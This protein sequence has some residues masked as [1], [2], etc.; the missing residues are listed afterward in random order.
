MIGESHAAV[1][2]GLTSAGSAVWIRRRILDRHLSGTAPSSLS[3]RIQ[4][5]SP[6]A[7]AGLTFTGVATTVAF[8]FDKFETWVLGDIGS[9]HDL[10]TVPFVGTVMTAAEIL[11]ESS[12]RVAEWLCDR[13]DI[14]EQAS[15]I[16][17]S[18]YD[19]GS[20]ILNG[21][22]AGLAAH[23]IQDLP[24]SGAGN[25]AIT[26]LK[27]LSNR[28]FN[29]GWWTNED[30]IPTDV[31][32]YGGG[33]LTAISWSAIAGYLITPAPPKQIAK[34]TL[35]DAQTAIET[36]EVCE[37]LQHQLQTIQHRIAETIESA[38]D[39]TEAFSTARCQPNS[40]Q[41]I[42]VFRADIDLVALTSAASTQRS[43]RVHTAQDPVTID[44]DPSGN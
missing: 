40:G 41:S 33:L 10:H 1:T 42:P 31:A 17:Q 43:E 19:L 14:P 24:G 2:A 6:E 7:L 22:V 12:Q 21:T 38:M 26:L 9:H 27:P 37:R 34:S 4:N 35:N 36:G 30:F 15:A 28:Q 44:P 13:L 16:G 5:R 11:K 23:I 29:L 39:L 25:S 3:T 32:L 18:L 20:W 8:G